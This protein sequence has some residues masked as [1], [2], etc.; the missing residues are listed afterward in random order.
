MKFCKRVLRM[1]FSLLFLL[2]ISWTTIS[3]NSVKSTIYSRIKLSTRSLSKSWRTE[4]FSN[5]LLGPTPS[6]TVIILL[7]SSY[8]VLKML[9]LQSLKDTLA[10]SAQVLSHSIST[11]SMNII[12]YPT[13]VFTFSIKTSLTSW[14][15]NSN[16]DTIAFYLT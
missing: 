14:T 6:F 1:I 2:R 4:R 7:S 13:L 3:S 12:P 11:D 16:R 10:T 15:E 9:F 8:Y 5:S